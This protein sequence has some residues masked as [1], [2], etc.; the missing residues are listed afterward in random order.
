MTARSCVR[1]PNAY[2]DIGT[3]AYEMAMFAASVG[4][5]ARP[6]RPARAQASASQRLT[7]MK[8]PPAPPSPPSP[9]APPP[10]ARQ[11]AEP[12]AG[13]GD[14]TGRLLRP[15]AITGGRTAVPASLNL[16]SQLRRTDRVNVSVVP[17]GSRRGSSRSCTPDRRRRNRGP[18][19]GLPGRRHQGRHRRPA[20]TRRAHHRCGTAEAIRVLILQPPREVLDGLDRL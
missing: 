4:R 17:V 15:Y 5:G 18:L 12:V 7:T 1:S 6:R 20:R 2:C 11:V 8:P 3:V 13:N 9:P 19:P 14:D 16:E 10:V